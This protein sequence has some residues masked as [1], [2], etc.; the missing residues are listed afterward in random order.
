LRG[1]RPELVPFQKTQLF[2]KTCCMD[3]AGIS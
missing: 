1:V 2:M 3:S